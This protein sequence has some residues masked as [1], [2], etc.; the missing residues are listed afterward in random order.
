MKSGKAILITLVLVVAGTGIAYAFRTKKKQAIKGSVS[1]GDI[2]IGQEEGVLKKQS[3]DEQHIMQ[4]QEVLNALHQAAFY[5]NNNCG[6]IKWGYMSGSLPGGKIVNE[7]GVFDD[8]TE[9]ACKYYLN[10]T[11][12]ELW[13]LDFIRQ[14]IDKYKSGNKCTYPLAIA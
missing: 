1:I 2:E 13:Y 3:T 6:G 8:K 10:R 12:V 5:I 14:K 11:E 4:L 9:Q 7:S